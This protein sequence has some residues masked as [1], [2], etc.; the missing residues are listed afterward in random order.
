MTS[1]DETE[2]FH[3]ESEMNPTLQSWAQS[4]SLGAI[5]V[6]AL[7]YERRSIDK[8]IEG[9]VTNSEPKSSA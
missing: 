3:I 4:L 6:G 2:S 9:C 5:I 7:A 1:D 8:A